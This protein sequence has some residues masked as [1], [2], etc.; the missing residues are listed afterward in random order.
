M[1]SANT[2][3]QRLQEEQQVSATDALIVWQQ[4]K[5]LERTCKQMEIVSDD[6]KVRNRL[7]FQYGDKFVHY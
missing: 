3:H 1:D 6:E 2:N 4:I 5:L 7:G